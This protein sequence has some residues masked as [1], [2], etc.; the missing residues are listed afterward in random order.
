MILKKELYNMLHLHLHNLNVKKQIKR[1][2]LFK[3][4]ALPELSSSKICVIYAYYERK[5]EQKNQKNLSFFI[6]YGLDES[7]WKHLDITYVFVINGVQCEVVIPKQNNIHIIKQHN[8]S[9]YQAWF[10]GIK[11]INNTFKSPI[12]ENFDYLCLLNCSTN[13]PFMEEDI[14]SHWLYPFYNKMKRHDAIACSPYLNIVPKTE[15]TPGPAL[16]CHFTLIKINEEIIQLLLRTK[17]RSV[18]PES[19]NKDYTL[20]FN[21]VIGPKNTKIDAILTGE[22]G[23]SRVLIKHNYNICCLYYDAVFNLLTPN[24]NKEREEFYHK[25]NDIL[26]NTI[27]IKNIWRIT[28]GYASPPVLYNFCDEFI[29]TKLNQISTFHNL[30][31]MYNYQLLNKTNLTNKQIYYDTYGYVENII[32]F[33]TVNKNRLGSCCAIYAHYD[34]NNIIADYV[35]QGIQ[36]LIYIGYNILF[37]TASEKINNIDL[38]TLP[39]QVHFITNKG[40][41]TDWL[42]WLKGLNNIVENKKKY[43]WIMMINDSLLFP[44][45][46]IQLFENTI[47]K[48]RE[49]ND[50]W[51]HWSSDEMKIHLVGTPIEFKNSLIHDIIQFIYNKI[52]ISTNEMDYIYLLETRFTQYLVSKGYN[53]KAIINYTDLNYSKELK[54]PIFHPTI[55]EQWINN[56]NTFAIKWKYSISYLNKN[57]V[58]QECNYLTRFLHYGPNGIISNGELIG[59][60]PKS[61][62]F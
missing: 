57:K 32:L 52:K 10:S 8:C 62:N 60:F 56:P 22:Y 48:M 29:N 21:T 47:I 3:S 61:R 35:I 42:I 40:K 44:I 24:I 19:I 6:K 18:Y 51:G 49:D 2:I 54:C 16:S 59:V 4:Q 53:Y 45:H 1:K 55:I 31:V 17:V 58:S 41:G 23:L 37:Y 50:F 38:E 27:F 12:W 36:S 39:F 33:P 30:P 28:D 15:P 46:G 26:K 34:S 9:D 7:K 13:G 20:Y 5:N 11:Y 25:N 43:D 14:N